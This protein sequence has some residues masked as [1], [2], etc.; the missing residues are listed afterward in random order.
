MLES[1]GNYFNGLWESFLDWGEKLV[2]TLFDMLK[3]VFL[4]LTDTI[5]AFVVG[6]LD[7]LG[8][9][10]DFN[11]GDYISA[12]PSE[13]TNI[14][15]VLGLNTCMTIIISAILIRLTLQIIPFTRLG[16]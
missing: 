3:D 1:I 12:L 2:N 4:W 8:Q 10:I 11:P 6:L 13:I 16:S 14:I 7:V 9:S 15:G 5:L